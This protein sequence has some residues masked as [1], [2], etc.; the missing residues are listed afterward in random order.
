EGNW[1]M[2]GNNTPIFF[3]K[4]PKKFPDF[5]HSQ[6]RDPHTN[7]RSATMQWDFWSLNPESLHQVIILMS[8]RGTPYTWRNMHGFGSHTYS[9]VNEAGDIHWVKFHFKTLQGIVNMTNEEAAKM[10]AVDLD[11]HQR[12]LVR[13]I[14]IGEYPRWRLEVQ[15]MTPEQAR[16]YRYNPFDLTKTWSHKDFPP[17]E[18]GI[19]E[20]NEI[21]E[22]YFETV[23]QASFAPSNI[24]PGIDFSPDKMLQGR[25]FAYADA[26][27]YRLG[28]NFAT[29]PVNRPAVPVTNYQRDGFM[30]FN[31]NGGARPNYTPN[32][33][34]NPQT[35][36]KYAGPARKLES[37]LA[38]W[39]DRNAPGEDD[40]YSQPRAL[41]RDVMTETDR[42]H[43]VHNIVEAMKGIDGPARAEIILRQMKHFREMDAD[44]AER[45]AKGL[46][47]GTDKGAPTRT[48]AR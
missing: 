33:F 14:A 13:S 20:L 21:P 27:R 6:K 35:D 17:I 11:F 40:H 26:A 25:I 5:I 37:E 31:G 3:I 47:L 41:Y 22:N 12:D 38:D 39:Y 30:A 9:F 18:V 28:A 2:V 46:G 48:V 8:D 7:L 23:E 43:L 29:L 45:V 32:S 10:K 42:E 4:D 44:F 36:P 1:D 24:V 19:L 16:T 15:I 34:D